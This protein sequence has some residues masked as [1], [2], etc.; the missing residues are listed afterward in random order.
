MRWIS[1]ARWRLTI[2][3]C[4]VGGVTSKYRCMSASAGGLRLSFVYKWM[5]AKYCPCFSVNLAG[6]GLRGAVSSFIEL[7][8]NMEA[9]R[10]IG[11]RVDLHQ[12][13]RDERKSLLTGGRQSAGRPKRAQILVAAVRGATDA[14][15]AERVA[16]RISTIS[17][18]GRRF[19]TG[20]LEL[21]LSE[22]P[23]SGAVRKLI[24]REGPVG[25]DGQPETTGRLCSLE[26]GVAS[27]RNG[28]V[29]ASRV[30][31]NGARIRAGFPPPRGRPGSRDGRGWRP[32]GVWSSRRPKAVWR[33]P[34]P[35]MRSWYRR[36]RRRC[37]G[38]WR[39]RRRL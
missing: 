39:P 13:E 23:R 22:A 12:S 11:Y 34:P 38:A 26:A 16:V 5:K 27:R 6:G 32:R 10:S 18:T 7:H 9:L 14:E 21:V 31:L 4:T 36:P 2:I 19:V 37:G 17:C 3:W 8:R 20:N 28:P 1:P 30:N 25:R 15:I 24:G 29:I 35:P 33:L